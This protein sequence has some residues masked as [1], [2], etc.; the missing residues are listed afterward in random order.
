[1]P[2]MKLQENKVRERPLVIESNGLGMYRVSVLG[3][4]MVPMV[5]RGLFTSEGDAKAELD[6]Y[7]GLLNAN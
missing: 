2:T 4:G 7:N 5:L 6:K 3:G 1:M